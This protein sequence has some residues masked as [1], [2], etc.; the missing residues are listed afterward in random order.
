MSTKKVRPL[1]T[2]NDPIADFLTRIRN[3][4][5]INR[6]TTVVPHSKVKLQLAELLR[7]EGYI[8]GYKEVNMDTPS[9]RGIEIELRYVN[10]Q[11]AIQGLKKVSKSGLR[12]YTKSQY[13]PRVRSGLGIS[14]I[15]T[16]NGLMTDRKARKEN[17][18][19]EIFCQVW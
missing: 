12:K 5:L 18:G 2:S 19:G 17:V 6:E 7:N 1:N 9:Q 11:P 10:G 3:A 15:S 16:S 4:I 13:A 8:N 14:V